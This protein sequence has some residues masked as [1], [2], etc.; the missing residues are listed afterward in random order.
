MP[1]HLSHGGADPHLNQAPHGPA[2]VEIYDISMIN[3]TLATAG[4]DGPRV[5]SDLL[6][7]T[8]G[9]T[10]TALTEFDPRPDPGAVD[11]GDCVVAI[12]A[13]EGADAP[14]LYEE[15][16]QTYPTQPLVMVTATDEREFIES[17]LDD[18]NGEYVYLPADDMPF[19]LISVRCKRLVERTEAAS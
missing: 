19:G 3:L 14:A 7:H 1:H 2:V 10:V 18:R 8:S 5:V 4:L 12:V 17:V 13:A 15:F 16:R 11:E 6:D 9:L